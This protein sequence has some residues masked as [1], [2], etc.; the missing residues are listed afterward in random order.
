M[1]I[2]I[3][4]K[5]ENDTS[6]TGFICRDD[7]TAHRKEVTG[8]VNRCGGNHLGINVHKTKELV[9]DC[10]KTG[11][12]NDN[13]VSLILDIPIG[14]YS[15]CPMSLVDIGHSPTFVQA[16]SHQLSFGPRPS[17]ALFNLLGRPRPW[18]N[19]V[20]CLKYGHSL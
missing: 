19:Q 20:Q 12:V 1:A 16:C 10:R 14:F 4:V 11:N 17:G 18:A 5:F 7:G 13:R 6:V 9:S 15:E 8:F 3:I 2:S